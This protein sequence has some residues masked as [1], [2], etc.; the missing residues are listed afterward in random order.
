MKF[1]ITSILRLTDTVYEMTLR[2][3]CSAFTMPGQFVEI[4]IP[5]L[6]LRRPISVCDIEGNRLT[7]VFKTVGK[8]TDAM[9]AM[10]PGMELDLL[11][12]LGK[13]FDTSRCKETALLAGGGVGVPPLYLLAR[14]L[15]ADGKKVK[16]AL[17]FNTADEIFY[18][19]KFREI[20]ADVE[21]ATVDGSA[22]V[23]GF[24]TDAIRKPE[25]QGFD[26]WYAC[27]PLPMLSA[28]GRELDCAIG[29]VSMEERMGCG[30]GACMGCTIDTPWGP[31]RVCK[32]GPVFDAILMKEF[33]GNG[34][35]T[36]TLPRD[37]K[38]EGEPEIATELCGFSLKN[39]LVPASGTFGFG[40]EFADIYDLNIL[41]GISIKG[42]TLHPR[43]GNITPRI[44]ETP[45][46]MIN[47]VG[48]QNPGA[49]TVYLHEVPELRKIYNGCIIANVSGFS[50][51]EYVEACRMADACD[52]VD[53]IE[54]NVSCPNVHNGGMA[55]GTSAEQA[56]EVTRAVKATVKKPVFIKL[57]PNVTNIVE[58]AKACEEAGADGLT[59][60]NT[61]LGMRININ[62]GSP[63]IANKMGGF[64]GPAVFP[65]AVRMVYQVSQA[66][67]IPVMGCGGVS[68][69]E[70]VVEMMMAGATAVQI[71][72]AN[73]V[74]PLACKKIAEELPLLLKKLKINNIKDIIGISWRKM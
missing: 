4:S 33:K 52:G 5:G 11:T 74:D 64:S 20:G 10:G 66:V 32:D 57:S 41:G 12:G 51:D 46:G 53:I 47:S 2:G 9:A 59:L 50:I 14:K 19:D 70:D 6:Y 35:P 21:V 28:L 54:V 27:G 68:S 63:V 72:S 48:L 24:V 15:I 18:A 3:D 71:G 8:G 58:I 1:E 39:P 36:P 26:F 38:L 34:T 22:G 45:D 40:Q 49:E 30:F 17:G 62:T 25:M 37:R 16:V 29:E 55:F 7:L 67:S 13:G 56:A 60:I 31:K 42:T 61:L 43:F 23:K 73:L 65:V 69:A 44:A